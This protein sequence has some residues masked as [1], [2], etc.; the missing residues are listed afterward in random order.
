MLRV[1]NPLTNGVPFF[2][3]NQTQGADQPGWLTLGNFTVLPDLAK[4]LLRGTLS[5]DEVHLSISGA[6]TGT[7]IIEGTS[8]FSTWL[9]LLMTNIAVTNWSF[10]DPLTA[11]QRFYRV[12]GQP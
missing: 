6:A 8:N 7:W 11:S 10:S 2:F 1:V 4:P 3:A 12:K 5:N 9:P